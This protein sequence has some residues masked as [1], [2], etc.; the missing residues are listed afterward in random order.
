ALPRGAEPPADPRGARARR[1]VP[2]ERRE[3][4][5]RAG[6]AVGALEQQSVSLHLLRVHCEIKLATTED[7]EDT[8]ETKGNPPR[9]QC[10][11]WWRAH[12]PVAQPFRAAGEDHAELARTPRLQLRG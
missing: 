4:Q 5:P 8:E 12:L 7:T 10:P 9:P 1:A 3:G 2:V 11:P 6:P